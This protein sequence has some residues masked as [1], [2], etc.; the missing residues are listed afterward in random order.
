[1]VILSIVTVFRSTWSEHHSPS[2][3][4]LLNRS[5]S[6]L[7]MSYCGVFG[8]HMLVQTKL[9]THRPGGKVHRRATFNMEYRLLY[10]SCSGLHLLQTIKLFT[11]LILA[12]KEWILVVTVIFIARFPKLPAIHL[13]LLEPGNRW[14]WRHHSCGFICGYIN[15]NLIVGIVTV[16]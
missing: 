7:K 5:S 15:V 6:S 1:M 16:V 4:S 14:Q 12:I 3:E 2:L 8:W 13:C 10:I 9:L 11:H